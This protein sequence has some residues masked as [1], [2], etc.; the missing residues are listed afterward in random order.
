MNRAAV[1]FRPTEEF[2]YPNSRTELTIRIRVAKDDVRGIYLEYWKRGDKSEKKIQRESMRRY[3]SDGVSDQFECH[4][5]IKP[6]AAYIRYRFKIDF[7]DHSS[8]WLGASKF[9]EEEEKTTGNFFEFLWPNPS[10]FQYVHFEKQ[11]FIFYQIFP[12]RFWKSGEKQ[13]VGNHIFE[14]WG[15]LPTRQNYM[16]GNLA[17]IRQKLPYLEK[18]G[19]NC[20][21]LNPVFEGTSNHRYDTVN[22]YRIDPDFG[23]EKDLRDLIGQAHLTGMK[24]LLDGVFNHCGY[25]W[26][27]FQDVLEKGRASKYRD[28]FFVQEYPLE[29]G[30]PKYDC[31]G[32]YRWMPKINLANRQAQDYFIAVG[33]YWIEKFQIDG[34]RLDVADEIPTQFWERFAFE[35]KGVS[36][37]SFLLGETW[38][39]ADR[40]LHG[41]RLDSAM[42]YLFRDALVDWLGSKAISTEEFNSRLNHM[43][44]LY[45]FEKMSQMYNLIDSH[46]TDRFL[47]A[48][49][50]DLRKLKIA[51]ALQMTFVG[52]PAVY[53]GDEVGMTADTDPLCR[54]CMNWEEDQQN[55]DLLRWY[56][57][58]IHFRSSHEVLLNGRF[59]SAFVVGRMLGFYRFNREESYL[60]ILNGG[61]D[62]G[63]IPFDTDGWEKI[64]FM[65]A[66]GENAQK[67]METSD[68]SAYSLEIWRAI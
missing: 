30:A 3:Y 59:Q 28:W 67:G 64:L 61:D 52:C 47:F 22:Y 32:F 10:D 6:I 63:K 9:C 58:L 8:T 14:P 20:L 17:G 4:I 34:W 11:R 65:P 16:G 23:E 53:Y 57:E 43:M 24:V 37:D 56:R 50:G 12:D 42:N 44:M 36:P 38:G 45:P 48:C 1:V 18:L 66:D 55:Q 54:A 33:K 13:E 15:S 29:S 19:V 60:V 31:V 25:A 62:R 40:L 2:I 51:V 21:Y 27:P 35:V 5:K 26:G 39:D 49:G 7:S 41:N 46:D 68:V